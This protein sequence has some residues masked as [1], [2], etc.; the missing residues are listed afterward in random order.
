MLC[1]EILVADRDMVPVSLE[2]SKIS[3]CV[4][5]DLKILYMTI[6]LLEVLKNLKFYFAILFIYYS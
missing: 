2:K 5:K 3:F 6:L 4:V 1:L